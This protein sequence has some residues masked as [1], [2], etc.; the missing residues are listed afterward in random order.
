MTSARA[1][2]DAVWSSKKP[3]EVSWF[4]ESAAPSLETIRRLVPDRAARVVD[5]GGG[6][7]RLVDALLDDGYLNL[8]V[9]DIAAPALDSARARL[10]A[11]ASR[12]EWI[13]G[14]ALDHRPAQRYRLWHDRAMLHFLQS[15]DDVARYRAALD[16]SLEPGGFAV[17]A[18]F[19]MDGPARCSNLDV[20]RYDAGAIAEAFAPA[21]Q[22][23]DDRPQAHRTPWGAEQRFRWFTLARR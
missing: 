12:V 9:V 7:S 20:R 6:A 1:H 22:V 14:D 21:F 4:Q 8:T 10:G 18:T 15:G 16:R 17:I 2:W 11:R 13:V 19:A 5:V 23:I 3:E